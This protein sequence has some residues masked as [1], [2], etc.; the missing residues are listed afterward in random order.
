MLRC[1]LCCAPLEVLD[2]VMRGTSASG[3]AADDV[4]NIFAADV[5]RQNRRN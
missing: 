4:G 5:G 2:T 1:G 3:T